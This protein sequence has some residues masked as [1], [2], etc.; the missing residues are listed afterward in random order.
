M[1]RYENETVTTI[2]AW[3]SSSQVAFVP[4]RRWPLQGK[5]V[6]TIVYET[7]RSARL[8]D[9]SDA[10]GPIG[11]Q[12]RESGYE[13]VVGSPI[14]VAGRA[15][16]VMTAASTAGPLASDTEG[17]LR[18]FTELLGTAIANAE[19]REAVERLA[20]EQAALRRIA[21]LVAQEPSPEDVFAAV[22]EAVGPLVG[23][24]AAVMHVFPS[25]GTALVVAGW[26]TDGIQLPIGARLSLDGDSA[27]T[28]VFHSRA[29]AR[30]DDFTEAAGEVGEFARSQEVRSAVGAPIIVSG[31]LWG[32]LVA[33]TRGTDPLPDEAESRIAA[34]TELIATAVANAQAREDV[35]RLAEEQAA[36]RRLA[37]LVAQGV[38]A[39]EIFMAV[40]DEVELLLGASAAVLRYGDDGPDRA[41]VVFVGISE[42]IQVPI[43]TRWPLREGMASME[44]YRTGRSARSDASSL[45]SV[46]GSAGDASRRFGVVS[47]VCA[48][49]VVGGRLWGGMFVGSTDEP[50]PADTEERLSKF[51]KIIATAI[52]NAE[53]QVEL[54]ASRRRIVA[55]SDEARRRIER[56]IHDGTQ[57]RLVSLGLAAR[58]AESRL[59]EDSEVRAELSRI[60]TGLAAAVEDL[61]EISRGLHPAILSRGGL[62]PALETLAGHAAVP[63]EL[64]MHLPHN[65]PPTVEVAAYYVVSEALTN[66]VKHAQ[67]SVVHVTAMRVDGTLELAVRDDGVGG[68]DPAQ[69]SGLTGLRD[70]VEALGGTIEITS[71]AGG[72]T[73]LFARI[74]LEVPDG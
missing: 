52:A 57:Q 11:V 68:A 24:D 38:P 30:M 62:A 8:D 69:G 19:S 5:N 39:T 34:F 12:A 51:T 48:P 33:A 42:S 72:G 20:D 49:I 9:F 54:A 46:E 44:V 4:G 73:S 10:T 60:A 13:S 45:A 55:A 15:W 70:R 40:S 67:A 37:T 65:L 36:L 64:D 2:A 29:P 26:S 22:T 61:Q 32:A 47:T 18:S 1:G 53:S 27:V 58:A 43:G 66:T 41:A 50:L 23:A 71:R 63:V 28:R 6:S 25:D 74:P 7:G 16:G 14:T 31:V 3:S 56:D 35:K 17:R 21:V 59:P